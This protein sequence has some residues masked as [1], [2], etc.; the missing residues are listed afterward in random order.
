M[1]KANSVA[2]TRQESFMDGFQTE[3]TSC[4]RRE[5]SEPGRSK[6]TG[7]LDE[8]QKKHGMEHSLDEY[9]PRLG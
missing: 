9:A 6:P 8:N 7:K 4:E 5:E 2:Y 3:M 1:Q